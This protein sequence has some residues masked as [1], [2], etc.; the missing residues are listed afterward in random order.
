MAEVSAS[1]LYLA[2]P[3]HSTSRRETCWVSTKIHERKV[4]PTLREMEVAQIL[5]N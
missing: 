5:P 2:P 1:D 3:S 4:I